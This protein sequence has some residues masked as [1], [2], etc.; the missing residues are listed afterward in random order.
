MSFFSDVFDFEK[1]NLGDMWDKVKEDPE[2]LFLGAADPFGTK[3]WSGITGQDWEPI[4]NQMGGATEGAYERAGEAGINTEPGRQM[5]GLAEVIASM[6]AGGYGAD[7]LKGLSGLGDVGGGSIPGGIPGVG[8]GGQ[9]Q[10][11]PNTLSMRRYE[12]PEPEMLQTWPS[13]KPRNQLLAEEL[14]ATRRMA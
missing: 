9:Q 8:G 1:F 2:R 14:R 6:Y 7:K 13:Q 4:V 5:H 10:R 11:R 12:Q 3:L